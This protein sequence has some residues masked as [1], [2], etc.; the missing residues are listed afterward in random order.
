VLDEIATLINC[1]YFHASAFMH[2]AAKI[3]PAWM[4]THP[5]GTFFYV[6]EAPI[7]LARTAE[8]ATHVFDVRLRCL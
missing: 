2:T 7:F 3:S 1:Q 6:C 8:S 4:L 5:A